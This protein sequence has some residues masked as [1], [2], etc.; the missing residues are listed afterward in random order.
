MWPDDCV[1]SP[2]PHQPPSFCIFPPVPE[3]A[4]RTTRTNVRPTQ[5]LIMSRWSQRLMLSS[6][7]N[8][9]H[10]SAQT[11]TTRTPSTFGT[12]RLR[13]LRNRNFFC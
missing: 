6:A 13:S 8:G 5:A 12:H 3:G 1:V 10:G 4:T 11:P 2:P 9:C 7:V